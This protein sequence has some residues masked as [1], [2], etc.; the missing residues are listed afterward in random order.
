MPAV[1][2]ILPFYNRI[3]TL[4]RCVDSVLAQTFADWEL[5]AVDDASTDGGAA[6]LEARGDP[7]IRIVRHEVN[8][9]AGA[10][11]D[12][13]M[14]AARGAYFALLDSDD[15]WLPGKLAAQMDALRRAGE[16]AALSACSYEFIRDGRTI[17]WPKPFDP[18]AWERSL[19]RE[20]TFGFGT[21]LVIRRDVAQQLGGF[22]PDL[23]RHEDWDWV[24]RAFV[25]GE[26]L[27]FVPETLARVYCSAPPPLDSFIT[28]TQRFL[29]KHTASFAKFGDKHRRRVVAY[30]YE[31]VASIAYEQRAFARGHRFLLRSFSTWPW[32]SPLPLAALPLG[33]V[34]A[35]CGTRLIQRAAAIR[36]A[37]FGRKLDAEV[38]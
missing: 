38:A 27:A 4:A 32:R 17:V 28:S 29:V 30:H 14:Q 13:A 5:V 2:V 6:M 22:D 3:A 1:S 21:T 24:L 9:G 8:R 10:A 7:R 25:K 12:T 23:P 18:T 26:T 31:S 16:T 35:V 33:A 20:C 37:M 15:E 19:H 36:R 11:R 34:D